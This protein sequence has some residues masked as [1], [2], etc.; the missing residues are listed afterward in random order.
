MN[1]GLF[2]LRKYQNRTANVKRVMC[3]DGPTDEERNTLNK[4]LTVEKYIGYTS[5]ILLLPALFLM[6]R[7]K[8]FEKPSPWFRREIG[9]VVGGLLYIQAMDALASEIMW[10]NCEVI[11]RKYQQHYEK[12][13]NVKEMQD[14]RRQ[15]LKPE[16]AQ[17]KNVPVKA[18]QG[19]EERLYDD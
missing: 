11:V 3:R 12:F 4:F 6:Y 5:R 1:W 8:M 7:R 2:Y 15:Q 18:M 10:G 16:A 14:A 19:G 17:A 9:I 13:M